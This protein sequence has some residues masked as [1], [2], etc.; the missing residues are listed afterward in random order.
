MALAIELTGLEI[1]LTGRVPHRDRYDLERSIREGGGKVAAKVTKSVDVVVMGNGPAKAAAA[2]TAELGLQTIDGDQ[3]LTLLRDGR[4]DLTGGADGAEDFADVVGELRSALALPPSPETWNRVVAAIDACA[5]DELEQAVE[6]ARGQLARWPIDARKA[7]WAS[8]TQWEHPDGGRYIDGDMRVAPAHWVAQMLQGEYSPKH[9]LA[10]ALTLHGHKA[11]A[12]QAKKALANPYLADSLRAL[13]MGRMNKFTK[14]LFKAIAQSPNLGALESLNYFPRVPGAGALLA[15]QTSMPNLKTLR[16]RGIVYTDYGK[17]T[18]DL[19][20]L[21][22]A[23]WLDQIVTFESSTT[24]TTGWTGGVAAFKYLEAHSDRF[25]NLR[26]IIATDGISQHMGMS[27]LDQL[28]TLTLHSSH[29]RSF[30]HSLPAI[31]ERGLPALE[32]LDLSQ[33]FTVPMRAS[34]REWAE[35]LWKHRDALATLGAPV[36]LGPDAP[37]KAKKAA[38]DLLIDA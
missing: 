29:P 14:G 1:F 23:D 7:R 37:A 8:M 17:T 5:E 38:G 21:F 3:L 33:V 19:E 27:C 12:T 32:D 28:E 30:D 4:L 36:Y 20:G 18:G 31:A 15:S 35:S 34:A 26:H 9:S 6:Y 2:K 13:D 10:S 24:I 22:E 25:T 16:I 11:N